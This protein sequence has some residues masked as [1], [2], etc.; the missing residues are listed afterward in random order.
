MATDAGLTVP[1]M[2][3]RAGRWTSPALAGARRDVV[4]RARTGQA[5]DAPT[6]PGGTFTVSNLGMLGIDRF[7]AILNP[8]QVAILAV[9]ATTQRPALERRRPGLAAG[10][11]AAP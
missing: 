8:P 1:V 10:R 6:S 9:G 11:R 2:H 4:S 3:R 5:D 7:D